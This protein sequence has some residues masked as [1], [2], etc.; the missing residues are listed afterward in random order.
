MPVGLDRQS[1]Y[2]PVFKLAVLMR[3]KILMLGADDYPGGV[4]GYV[5][6]LATLCDPK[7]FEFHATVSHI[8]EP[9][10]AFLHRSITKHLM[11]NAYTYWSLPLRMA[12][13]R[14]I[15]KRENITLVHLHT[16]RAGLLGCMATIGLPIAKVYTGH[17][18]RFEQK[19]KKIERLLFFLYE[20]FICHSA[21]VVA[22]LTK[23]DKDLGISKGLVQRRKAVTIITRI[24]SE[25]IDKATTVYPEITRSAYGIQEDAKVI[26]NVGDLSDRKDPTTFVLAAAKIHAA[27]P[28]AYFLWIG[29][30]VLRETVNQLVRD[31]GLESR[32]IITGFK[33]AEQVPAFLKL[34]DVFLFTSRIEGVPLAVLEAQLCGVLVVSSTYPGVN[35]LIENGYT[36]YTFRPGHDEEAANMVIRILSDAEQTNNMAAKALTL[37][38][39]NHSDP[40]RMAHQYEDIYRG[41]I[42]TILGS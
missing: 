22:F 15:L 21:T 16:A 23:R 7:K 14:R 33:P 37:A 4:A 1:Q 17:S 13:L 2:H 39:A 6:L 5:N 32:F 10:L 24:R 27:I 25:Y 42:Q 41:A 31:S 35:E 29:D 12:Q 28:N 20:A 9:G 40:L 38:T 34:M 18:W 36:G 26:G 8:N 19:M 3:T 30:G 11:P